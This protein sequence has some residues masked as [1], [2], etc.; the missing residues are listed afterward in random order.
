MDR[1]NFPVSRAPI[2][3]G[4]KSMQWVRPGLIPN[5]P[6]VPSKRDF[7][8]EDRERQF[9]TTPKAPRL[10]H[11]VSAAQSY[12]DQQAKSVSPSI[13][14]ASALLERPRE[15]AVSAE[16]PIA[17]SPKPSSIDTRR[18]SDVVMAEA[19]PQLSRPPMSAASSAPEALQDSDD[20]DVDLDEEDFAES[21]AKY[22]RERSRLEAKRIDLSAS[23]LR[24]TSPLQEIVLLSC[25]NVDHL[26][27]KSMD[28]KLAASDD[29]AS[30]SQGI[31]SPM[32]IERP[33]KSVTAELPTPKAEDQDE[34][35][36]Q[37]KED[38]EAIEVRS[39]APATM[40]LRLRRAISVDEETIPDT[41]SL[42]YLGSGPPTPLSDIGQDRPGLSDSVKLAIRDKLRR[43]IEPERSLDE[44][45]H[46]YAA[47][48]KQWRLTIRPWDDER[49]HDDQERPPSAE[50]ALR[51]VTPDVQSAAVTGILDG[52]LALTG[53][54]SHSSRWATELD[55]EA[56]I[57][58]SLKT[59][60]EE[61][62]GKKEKEP[63]QAMADPEK[64]ATLPLELTD[65]EAH[66][67]RYIDTNFQREPGQGIFVFHYEPP[68]DDFTVEEHRVMVH[69]Y[70]D[71]Y[72]KKWGKLAEV[73]YKEVGTERTY[74]DCI[75]HYY[76]TKWGRE[77]KGK[78]RG[79]RG[80]VRKRGGGVARGRGAIANM[81]RPEQP[82]EDGHPLP[83]TETGRPRRS[84]APTF[85]G[86]E[87]DYDAA[88][89]SGTPA[90]ARRQT[91]ADGTQDKAGRRSK[92][93]KDKI[94]RKPK[95][96]PLAAAP[97]GFPVKTD[98]KEK[99][100]GV[101]VE[102]DYGKRQLG[103]MSLPVNP[104]LIEEQ[105][106][107]PGNQQPMPD[108]AGGMLD[109]PKNSVNARPGPSSYWSVSELQDFDKNVAH[110]GTDWLAIANHMGTKT[111]T[112]IKN[113]YLRLVENGRLE[114]EQVAKEADARRE[115]GDELGPAPTPTPAPKRR[116]ESTQAAPIRQLAPTPE[117][118]SPDLN[119]L[120]LSKPSPPHSASSSR[121]SNIAQ[122]PV[123]GKPSLPISGYSTLPE[124]SL[125]SVPSIPPQQS[126]PALPQR[127]PSQHHHQHSLSQHKPP[128]RAGYFSDDIQRLETRPHSQS[129]VNQ[130]APRHLQQHAPAQVRPQEHQHHSPLYRA[131]SYHERESHPRSDAQQDQ[132][133]QRRFPQ[134]DRRISHEMQ[135]H[136]PFTPGV[137]PQLM[138][139]V[140][141]NSGLRSPEHRPMPYS[142]SRHVSQAQSIGQP[143]ND[144]YA[145]GHASTPGAQQLPARSTILT[146][147][148]KE[149]PRIPPPLVPQGPAQSQS[150]PQPQYAH[151]NQPVQ[152]A[153][154]LATAK[155][156]V[157]PRKSNLMSLLNDTDPD[158]PRRKKTVDQGPPSHSTTPQQ[159][160]PIAP[161]PPTSQA[162]MSSRRAVYD[163]TPVSQTPSYTRP[164]YAQQSAL[165]P[166][167]S[168]RSIDLTTEQ[169]A[170]GRTGPRDPWPQRQQF[171]MSQSQ[172]QQPTS[173]STSQAGLPQHGFGD[174]RMF[175]NHRSV[176]A[177]H[178]TARHNPSPPPL[179]GYT[180]SP[181]LHSRTPSISGSSTQPARHGVASTTAAQ[182]AQVVAASAQI[183]QPNPY[184]A[185]DPPGTATTPSGPLGMRPSPHLQTS[186]AALQRDTTGRNEHAQVQNAALSY[187]NP[188]TP[189]EHPAH[190]HLRGPSGL[191]EP[192]RPRDPHRDLEPRPSDRDTGRELSQRTDYMQERLTNPNL[193]TTRPPMQ[194]E[195]R[196]QP[197]D[198]SY[199]AQRAHTPISRSEHGQPPPL[200]HPPHSSLGVASHPLYAQRG[201]EEPSHRFSQPFARD[202]SISDRIRDEQA[203]QQAAM[204]RDAINRDAMNRDEYLRRENERDMRER[205]IRDREAHHRDNMM[206]GRDMRGPPLPGSGPEQRPDPRAPA[207]P[208]PMDWSRHPQDRSGWQR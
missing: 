62:N 2:G 90:R 50:P 114:L 38:R 157:E 92:V 154:P 193:Q 14:R 70:K 18:H 182:H 59:A 192:Y 194:D 172:S 170:I 31:E 83:V 84:A 34:T 168:N 51:V 144:A 10:E 42:P 91:D 151:L 186:H 33:T 149:E 188:Q 89:V 206:R 124:T 95:N 113:Q 179:N 56:A 78:I 93:A 155:P 20:E 30:V 58:E 25:L 85:G 54:R 201:P 131:T 13:P 195:L 204:N 81:D 94:G 16:R 169:S 19:S 61:R 15:R 191:Q 138:A 109:R 152:T 101:K 137:A 127:T 64:E 185:V 189:I 8:N 104:V 73:L 147:P 79:R 45:L 177:Q 126:P 52:S 32:H 197:P 97:S 53:R 60:E 27:Q 161:P 196:Y 1:P 22:N 207:G 105:M 162:F 96:M 86:N 132:E 5:R 46:Q 175:G 129:L 29:V 165:P 35:E 181:H 120:A 190:Q 4:P 208:G 136:K 87:V 202:R 80:G 63:R 47:A 68:E 145:T 118:K 115:R 125:A 6:T 12:R 75:N 69:N 3:G 198:R 76:A 49:E 178:N 28:T 66:R 134:H 199:L 174:N 57:K 55:L 77:Y 164:S 122:A 130:Q 82:G 158:E 107:L 108:L 135:N 112:M 119:P 48:Y 99:G 203:Q 146:P 150:H 17:P 43:S 139:P 7:P 88:A 184:A 110:F 153:T 171:H 183:L 176:F 98:R 187:S 36:L 11:S 37:G 133:N 117:H 140:R 111:H 205:E 44:T 173:L 39:A 106:L 74:K 123:Q 128:P 160:A 40:A 41:T 72:A 163:D 148:V 26:P 100:L 24:A 141:S 21:E 67:R 102:D 143:I 159:A 142:H 9:G 167:S 156:A 180:N 200:Q 65:S 116:Y 121:F 23:H 103:E 71:Q 166:T